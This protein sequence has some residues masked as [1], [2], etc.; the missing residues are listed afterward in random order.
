M[1]QFI[2]AV[3]SDSDADVLYDCLNY[4]LQRSDSGLHAE[5][6]RSSRYHI[7]LRLL[8]MGH[9]TNE[10]SWTMEVAKVISMFIVNHM[11]SL[12]LRKMLIKQHRSYE[13]H[14]LSEIIQYCKQLL[15]DT[16]ASVNL[17]ETK[18]DRRT[19]IYNQLCMYLQTNSILDIEGFVYFR[20]KSYMSDLQDIVEDAL[21]EFLLNEQYQE[22]IA[23][24]KY[25]VYFQD[26][27][28]PEV[29]L[30][31]QGNNKFQL[32]DGDLQQL[33]LSD[34]KDVIVETVD[35]ELNYEDMVVSALISASPKQIHIHTRDPETQSIKTIQQ[36]FEGR[37]MIC[38]C[39]KLCKPSLG[40]WKAERLT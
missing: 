27:K 36:I 15:I 5:I 1:E 20:L 28:I 12:I 14:E 34:A 17:V 24:L 9:N 13:A 19:M 6:M 37:T 31:H 23:L 38:T 33:D 25:F 35:R 26:T 3:S 30:I 22:F 10:I 8:N 29:H 18:Q 7:E 16:E 2:V 40:E 32:L 11:E 21:N 39:C 4:S